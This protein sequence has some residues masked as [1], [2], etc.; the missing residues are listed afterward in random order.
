MDGGTTSTDVS[1]FVTGTSLNWSGIT[2]AGTGSLQLKVAD[3]AGND[4]P[5]ATQAYQVL[6]G[7][8]YALHQDA[9]D[10]LDSATNYSGPVS[11]LEYN[12]YG[13]SRAEAVFGTNHNDFIALRGDDAAN[14]GAGD[15]VLNG[16]TGSN[17]LAG[18]AG[19]GTFFV[20]VRG[21]GV[22][23]STIA[24]WEQGEQLAVSGWQK[25]VSQ[26][27]WVENA[28]AA[29]WTGATMHIDINGNG[30]IDASATWTALSRS[31][32]VAPSETEVERTGLLWFI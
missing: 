21:A 24:D 11:G 28:G 5:V 7:P 10:F 22:T 30:D 26:A 12:W 23:W 17:F 18:G 27:S 3:L 15:D 20:D 19:R 13:T 29:G 8:R 25:G 1:D 32:I 14:G 4:G 16:G 2:L 31:Q 6:S 9:S